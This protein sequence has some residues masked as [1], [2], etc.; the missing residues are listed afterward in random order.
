MNKVKMKRV[1]ACLMGLFCTYSVMVGMAFLTQRDMMYYPNNPDTNPL[2][3]PQTVGLDMQTVSVLTDDGL[4]L[5]A[6]FA[7]PKE[8]DA[9][10]VVIFHGNANSIVYRGPMA[11]PMLKQGY[12]VYL[13]EY[14]GFGGNPGDLSEEG[15]Y[16]DARAGIRWLEGKGYK[17]EQLVYYGESL[18]TGVAVQ[19][20]TETAPKLLVLQSPFTKIADVVRP[21]MWFMPVDL[22]LRDRYD[23]LA[24]IGKFSVPVLFIHG[25]WDTVISIDLARELFKAANEPK[26]FLTVPG[27]NHDN[28]YSYGVGDKIAEWIGKKFE[29]P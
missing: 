12:G 29:K 10:V 7:P 22:L 18:G 16:R 28:L 13:C 1:L 3:A 4:A 9:P 14:R 19:M 15:L 11:V 23:S 5:Q 8:K 20:A 2:P 6:W 27:G 24:K 21:N 17:K 25:D 26:A